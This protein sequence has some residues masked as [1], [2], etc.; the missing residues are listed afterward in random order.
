METAKAMMEL[1][2][3]AKA[4]VA[5][6]VAHRAASRRTMAKVLTFTNQRQKRDK[7]A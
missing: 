5:A 2:A 3:R 7:S 4:A 6:S 1:S